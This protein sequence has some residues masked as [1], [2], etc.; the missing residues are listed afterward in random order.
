MRLL[1]LPSLSS[2]SYI[3]SSRTLLLSLGRER[4]ERKEGKEEKDGE[5]E[6]RSQPESPDRCCS[7]SPYVS[8]V[9]SGA[10]S[11]RPEAAS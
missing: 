5:E 3:P 10:V 8:R 6:I 9:R 2:F 4:K 11:A 1:S 7:G